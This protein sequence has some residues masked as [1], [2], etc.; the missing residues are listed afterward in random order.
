MKTVVICNVRRMLLGNFKVCLALPKEWIYIRRPKLALAVFEPILD[1]S[2]DL[3]DVFGR[4][5]NI[6]IGNNHIQRTFLDS[7]KVCLAFPEK[8]LCIC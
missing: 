6:F 1:D 2:E 4:L 3:I 7:F 5:R 8:W